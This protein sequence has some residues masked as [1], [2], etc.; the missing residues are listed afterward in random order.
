[1][2]LGDRKTEFKKGISTDRCARRRNETSVNLR[3]QKKEESL[4]K[5][6]AR[7][8]ENNFVGD[9]AAGQTVPKPDLPALQ[10]LINAGLSEIFTHMSSMSPEKQLLGTTAVRKILSK[11]SVYSRPSNVAMLPPKKHSFVDALPAL[12]SVL[13]LCA[14]SSSFLCHFFFFA[15]SYVGNQ[16]SCRRSAAMR[17]AAPSHPVLGP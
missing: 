1:M 17:S 5:R 13:F 12:L 9:L 3:K 2:V 15:V 10:N 7:P 4:N 16:P 8:Q 6:R 14:T 11:V